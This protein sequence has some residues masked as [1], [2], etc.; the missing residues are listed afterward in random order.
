MTDFM[1]RLRARMLAE[2]P[3][4]AARPW[5]NI[6]N[7]T[8][9]AGESARVDLYDE[10]GGWFGVPAADFVRDLNAIT[11]DSID[12]HV[13][14]PG[15][16]VWDGVAILN[17]IRDHPANVTATVDG[18]AASAA[19]FIVMGA[20]TIVMGRNSEMMIHD[21]WGIVMGNAA[22]M[23]DFSA[24]LDSMSN[25]IASIYA[26]RTGTTE[27]WRAAMKA[28][29][30]YSAQEAVDAGLADSVAAAKD[31]KP[32]EDAKDRFDLSIYNYAGRRAA[33]EPVIPRSVAKI[34]PNDTNTNPEGSRAVPFNDDVSK[35]LGLSGDADEPTILAALDEALSERAAPTNS[36]IPAG[37]QLI[38]SETLA[39]LQ[40]QAAAGASARAQQ[41]TERR[42]RIVDKA[43][44]D[45][46]FGPARR[47]DWLNSLNTNE[48]A[49]TKDIESLAK[50]LIPVGPV[51]GYVDS[52]EGNADADGALLA[53]LGLE[54]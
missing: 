18:V 11:A 43:I 6:Q 24:R 38:D 23:A 5:Y 52:A 9:P 15:G 49:A 40:N 31:D 53:H 30:W 22:D 35:R 16:D 50:G 27:E 34:R 33:P 19:S 51:S 42:E 25:N 12:L 47:E 48:A 45:G 2:A 1:E 4:A 54:G 14:S 37:T 26:E 21:A 8:P 7:A 41:D 17:A 36:A 44:S 28:E 46:K 3:K 10:I 13:N 39:T 29:S 20:D 32:A